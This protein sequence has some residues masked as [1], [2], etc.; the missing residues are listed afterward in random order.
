MLQA[1]KIPARAGRGL[2]LELKY[3][4]DN[5]FVLLGKK[6]VRFEDENEHI[7]CLLGRGDQVVELGLDCHAQRSIGRIFDGDLARP[8]RDTT[9]HA[10]RE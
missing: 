7:F 10:D 1:N 3:H 2:Q 4:T 5:S 9:Q 6:I 8:F